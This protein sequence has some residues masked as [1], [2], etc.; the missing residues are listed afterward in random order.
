MELFGVA[1]RVYSGI[2]TW[3]DPSMQL[4]E[5]GFIAQQ[6]TSFHT[7]NMRRCLIPSSKSLTTHQEGALPWMVCSWWKVG[8][9]C[10]SKKYFDSRFRVSCRHSSHERTRTEPKNWARSCRG[11]WPAQ[12]SGEFCSATWDVPARYRRV[13]EVH[14]HKYLYSC[15]YM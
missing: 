8:S 10:Q 12:N 1:E 5:I 6:N 4:P 15:A 11:T 7:T 2:G 14:V 3:K 13:C 9:R